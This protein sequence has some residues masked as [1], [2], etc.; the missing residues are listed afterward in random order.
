VLPHGLAV[1]PVDPDDIVLIRYPVCSGD[2]FFGG[3]IDEC[4][5]LLLGPDAA[6]A[7]DH[8]DSLKMF[9]RVIGP[10]SYFLSFSRFARSAKGLSIPDF[11]CSPPGC[12][13]STHC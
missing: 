2:H 3:V 9:D 11:F 7:F 13:G 5:V 1:D 12:G 10:I 6:H 8:A 4:H